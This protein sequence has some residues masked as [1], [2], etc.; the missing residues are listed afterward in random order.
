MIKRFT[1]LLIFLFSIGADAQIILTQDTTIC[2]TQNLTLQAFSGGS[3]GSSLFLTDDTHSPIVSIGFPF[4]FYG[5]SYTDLLIS[6]NGYI[7][8]DLA[9]AGA[10]S[11]WTNNAAIPM[12]GQIP[13]NAIM[14][15]WQDIDPSVGGVIYEGVNGVAPN[16]VYVVTWCAVPMFQCNSSLSTYQIKLYEGS[17]KIE[18]FL[19]DKPLCL[20]WAGGTAIQGLVD[21]TSTNFD[22]VNDPTLLLPRNWPLTWTA[23]NEGWEFIPNATGTGYTINAITYQPIVAGTINWFDNNWAQIGTG[24]SITVSPTSTTTYYASINRCDSGGTVIDSITITLASAIV[25]QLSSNDATCAGNDATL[26]VTPD[27]NTTSPPWNI[28]LLD[29]NGNIVLVQNN[30]WTS[31]TFTN[32]FPGT[33]SVNVIEPINGC[34][35]VNSIVVKQV[36]IDLSLNAFSQNV[37]CFEGNDGYIAVYADSGYPPY[38]FFIDGVLNANPPPYDTAFF[39]NLTEGTYIL[40][41]LDTVNCM[42]RDTVT[43]TDPDYPLQALAASKTT[44]CYGQAN[45]TAVVQG[46]GGTPPYTYNWYNSAQI[47]FSNN[48]SVTGLFAGTYFAEVT[49]ANGCDTFATINVIQ[50]QTPITATVQIMD[51]AC[52][53]DSSGYI[54]ATA[55]GSYAPYSYYWLGGADTLRSASPPITTTRDSLNNLPTG[56][57][58]LHVYDAWGCMESYSNVVSEPT[59]P[60]ADTLIKIQDIDCFGDS[61]GRVQLIV[62]GGIVNYTYLWD[63]GETA[64]VASNLTAG[65]H[66]VWITDDWG[67]TIEDTITINENPL[68]ENS[69]TII[70]NVS[71]YGGSDG[72][73]PLLEEFCHILMIGVMVR[74]EYPSQIQTQDYCLV[75][76]M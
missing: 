8:F 55:G 26:T 31:H 12:P 35:G 25:S 30:V 19:Q 20:T 50:P 76:I 42:M 18:M 59:N 17:N 66:T 56:S 29:N 69:I 54:V 39:D 71:C 65:L 13:E 4:T 38:Q 6:T 34:S 3:N 61:T 74:L 33:Y 23:T 75:L 15:P 28:Q 10:F 9:N 52:K 43:I 48:D 7:T 53:G 57:Y 32:L 37:S 36:H 1:F 47:S 14:A 64:I 45:G 24:N 67:C 63:N 27:L 5:T 49:D 16:R 73:V 44:T 46:A 11:P 68:I 72:A 41:V 22:I 51:V 40:S 60:L 70:Q 62:S 21:A 2:G 58:E